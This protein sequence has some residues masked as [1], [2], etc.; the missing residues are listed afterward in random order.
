[1]SD[2]NPGGDSAAL[3]QYALPEYRTRGGITVHRSAEPRPYPGAVEPLVDALD[4]QRG[5]LLTSS[6]EY[7]GRYTRWDIGFINPL[8]EFNATGRTFNVSALNDRGFQLLDAI[9]RALEAQA[10]V[11]DL[12]R[13]PDGFRGQIVEPES[14]FPEELRSKQPTVFSVLRAL[15]DLFGSDRDPYLGFYGAFG[16]ELA[17]QFE[18]VR[19]RLERDPDQRD[20]VLYLADEILVV[21]HRREDATMHIYDFEV[22]GRH[23]RAR[24]RGGAWEPY[25]GPRQPERDCDHDPGEYAA[26]VEKAI[27]AFARGDLFEVVPGQMF[28]QP[29]N[30]PPS[31]LF[32]RLRKRNPAPYGALMNLGRQEYLVA[33]SPEMFV[34]VEGRRIETCPISGT[35]AR[36]KNAIADAAQIRRLME[37]VKEESELTMCTDVDRNDK[38]R[39]CEAGSVKVIGRRQIEMYSRLIHTVDHVEGQLR[40]GYDGLDGFLAHAWAVTVTGAPKQHAI[41]FIEDHE[42]S[43]R[44][45]YGGAIGFL[46]FDGLAQHR[47]YAAHRAGEQRHR[48][49][50][51]RRDAAV[52]IGSARGGSGDPP[53]GFRLAGRDHALGR[54]CSERAGRDRRAYR[55]RRQGAAR[56]SRRLLRAHARRLLQANR[57]GRRDLPC[58][59]SRWNGW[60]RSSRTSLSFRRDRAGRGT[61]SCRAPSRPPWR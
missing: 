10:A 19:R 21:D 55:R 2:I 33:A 60:R 4:G 25:C 36:G 34:R 45:W 31:E 47:S 18:P 42:R 57:R 40:E 1:M 30:A 48:R 56:R 20:L 38:S 26:T 23:T 53:Q 6:F 5:V 3:P 14:G 52:R 32:R 17:F 13:G 24:P 50:A 16:Y 41:Q 22:D 43:P 11:V 59:L 37:S 27:E 58:R 29:C 28:F 12:E 44:R 39:V 46:G 61:S 7:P 54:R 35:I 9:G 49:G 15:I 8:L 51:R